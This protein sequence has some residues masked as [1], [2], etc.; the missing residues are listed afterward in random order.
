M[1]ITYI[2]YLSYM[3]K[4]YTIEEMNELLDSFRRNNE[5][6]DITGLMLYKDGNVIQ[7]IEGKE[8]DVL[9]L[10]NNISNDK[11]HIHIIKLLHKQAENRMFSDWK[12]GFVNYN[13]TTENSYG[14]TKFLSE[15][16]SDLCDDDKIMSL[17]KLFKHLNNNH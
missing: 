7:L 1:S 13:K 16:K 15:I 11:T 9:K 5:I 4:N 14:F 10:Y 12:M 2:V 17:F 3:T 6:H 8:D